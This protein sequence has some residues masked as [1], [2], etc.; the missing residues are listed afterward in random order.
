MYTHVLQ[1][2]A[3]S[4]TFPTF[5]KSFAFGLCDVIVHFIFNDFPISTLGGP[6]PW[7]LLEIPLDF[8]FAWK[9]FEFINIKKYVLL[10]IVY[11]TQE[12]QGI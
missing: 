6:R 3:R 5:Y 10:F 8:R 12:T 11:K 1:T 4:F 7:E 9:Y 2:S